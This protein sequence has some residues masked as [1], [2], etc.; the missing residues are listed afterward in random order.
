MSFL[1]ILINILVLAAFVGYIWLVVVA[2]KH[3]LLW[4]FLV[5]FL[6]PITAPIF[7]IKNWED[8]KRPFL[9]YMGPFASAFALGIFLFF[10]VSASMVA[11][12]GEAAQGVEMDPAKVAES[13]NTMMNR[14]EE[15]GNLDA[16]EQAQLGEMRKML[17]D[18]ILADAKPEVHELTAADLL[19]RELPS[20][21]P[22]MESAPVALPEKPEG[23]ALASEFAGTMTADGYQSV[24]LDAA[25]K[26]VGETVRVLEMGGRELIG[27]L[28]AIHDDRLT[29]E[30]RFTTGTFAIEVEKQFIEDLQIY[31]R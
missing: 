14:I 5:L 1:P 28:K 3:S 17:N 21:H 31:T 16:E 23:M 22:T 30:K 11:M 27:K 8:A 9:V 4:G 26:Y 12:V 19:A 13:M 10:Y 15:T 2:F 25:S 18:E 24:P 6:S 7:A 20:E 29:L